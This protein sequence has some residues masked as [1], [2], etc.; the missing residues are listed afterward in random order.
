MKTSR[1]LALSSLLFLVSLSGLSAQSQPKS[2]K[3]Y[4]SVSIQDRA[5]KNDEIR[6]AGIADKIKDALASEGIQ[7]LSNEDIGKPGESSLNIYVTLK[8]SLKINASRF[9]DGGKNSVITISYPVNSYA[10]NTAADI[11]DSVRKYV[12]YYIK[13]YPKKSRK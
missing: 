8:D 11:T 7:I 10:Y 4:L 3:A 13:S 6:K 1:L 9:I 5:V 12:R 2:V